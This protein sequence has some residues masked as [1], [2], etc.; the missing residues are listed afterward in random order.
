MVE[1]TEPVLG[2][3]ITNSDSLNNKSKSGRG[4]RRE[5]A[6]RKPGK[7]EK[8]TLERLAIK[9]AMID[10]IQAN[11][12]KLVSAQMS[13]ALGE[14]YLMKQVT[15]GTGAK[16]RRETSIVT[17]PETIRQYLDDELDYDQNTEYYYMTT[18]PSDNYALM[19]L[20]DRAFGKADARV[21]NSGEQKLI[22]E[23]RKYKRNGD[24]GDGNAND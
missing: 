13:K 2:Q 14:T 8:T 23:T 10:R 6:G 21:E 4:G 12:D 5:G 18:K 19:G 22:I 24:N 3:Q 15:I 20:L 9:Q 11:A 1:N 17:N 16:Q 7:M